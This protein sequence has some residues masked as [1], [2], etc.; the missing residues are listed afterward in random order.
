MNIAKILTG[1]TLAAAVAVP[2]TAQEPTRGFMVERAGVAAQGDASVDLFTGGGYSGG[3]VRLGLGNSE[4]ILNSEKA[5]NGSSNS[6][7]VFKLGLPALQGLSELKHSLAVYGGIAVIDE[8][9]TAGQSYSNFMIGAAFTADM[10]GLLLSIA[11]EFIIDDAAD[12]N[13]LDVGLSAHLKMAKGQYGTF[14]PGVEVIA[15]TADNKD[16]LF[17]AGV[18]WEYNDRLTLDVVPFLFGGT[19]TISLPGQMRVNA[20]F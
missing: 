5:G 3:A 19:D 9:I 12:D 7:A 8:D 18:R 20:R 11:P 1:M 4:L 15:T 17:G 2:V 10:N 6:E 16:T 13:Y 14:Q